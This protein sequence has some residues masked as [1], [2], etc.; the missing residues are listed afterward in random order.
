MTTRPLQTLRFSRAKVTTPGGEEIVG[1]ASVT[2]DG[3]VS[4]IPR[5]NPDAAP[6][7][8]GPGEVT[9]QG[10]HGWRVETADGVV[11]V[12]RAPGVCGSCGGRR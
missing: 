2:V 1:Q 6:T 12:E 9:K 10:S 4:V 7:T 11:F 5:T 8:F 3:L